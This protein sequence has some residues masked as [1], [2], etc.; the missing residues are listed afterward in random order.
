MRS[1]A[2]AAMALIALLAATTGVARAQ[3]VLRFNLWVPPTHHTHT[4]MMMPWAAD[5]EK[6]TQG[7]VKIEFTPSSLGAP[8]RQFD[9]AAEGVADI[10][11]GDHAYTPG[12]FFFTKMAEL[13][14]LGD[15]A[16]ALSVAHWRTYG[17]MPEAAKE[18]EDTKLLS[19]F[20]HGPAAIMTTKK[21]VDSVAAMNGLKIRVPGETTSKIIRLLGGV[22]VSVPATQVFELLSQGVV[23]GSVYNI[24]AYKNFRLDRFMKF[25]TTVPD[26]LYNISFF[27]VMNKK[28]WDALSKAD[29]EA[30]ESVSGEAFARRAGKVWDDEDKL[31]LD[32]MQ[33]NGVEVTK[34]DGKFLE[35]V[36]GKLA[37]MRAEWLDA[38]SKRGVDGNKLL[39]HFNQEYKA[40]KK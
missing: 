12:R 32:L 19:V 8:P 37:E 3:T 5:V 31:A 25:V 13:P 1:T 30:I 11:F 28:K 20:M 15:S 4:A 36:K 23:D 40:V 18:H 2:K 16:E 24:D 22:P 38:A 14:F 35:E 9:L 21:K 33:K 6:A 27:L 17:V 39:A 29:Q 10:T 26:G 7:R 34:M